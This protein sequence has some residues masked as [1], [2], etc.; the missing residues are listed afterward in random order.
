MSS[1]V[2]GKRSGKVQHT[3]ED[4][5]PFHDPYLAGTYLPFTY[6]LSSLLLAVPINMFAGHGNTQKVTFTDILP[7]CR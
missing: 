3:A 4:L 2:S 6:I 7:E 1:V 5:G